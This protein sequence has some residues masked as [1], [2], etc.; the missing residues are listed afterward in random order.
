M[1]AGPG[2]NPMARKHKVSV[3]SAPAKY[4]LSS[5]ERHA[6]RIAEIAGKQAELKREAAERRAQRSLAGGAI[7]NSAPATAAKKPAI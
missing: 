5:A 4:R 6:L 3:S 1:A 7:G 2:G